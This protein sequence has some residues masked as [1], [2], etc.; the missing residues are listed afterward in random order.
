MSIKIFLGLIFEYF[1]YFLIF[2]FMYI[3]LS[4]E[5]VKYSQFKYLIAQIFR[6]LGNIKKKLFTYYSYY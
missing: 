4:H 3:F 6:L 2:L 5:N 1:Y